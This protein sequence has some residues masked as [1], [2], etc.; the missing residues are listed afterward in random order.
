MD[1]IKEEKEGKT[2]QIKMKAILKVININQQFC[3]IPS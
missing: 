2:Y 3:K 1:G